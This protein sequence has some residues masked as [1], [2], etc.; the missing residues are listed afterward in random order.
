MNQLREL[1]PDQDYGFRMTMWKGAPIDFFQSA[2]TTG[3]ILAER[4][5]CLKQ[6]A[7]VY[8]SLTPEGMSLLAEANEM[9]Q[10]WGLPNVTDVVELAGSWEPDILFLSQDFEGRFRLRGGSLCFPT[11]WALEEKLGLTLESIHGIVPG[12]NPAIGRA[13]D[14]FLAGLKSG[15]A[16]RRDNWGIAAT[17]ELNLHPNRRIAPPG[18]PVHLD[19]MWLRVE[20]QALVSLPKNNGVMFAIRIALHRLDDLRKDDIVA[21]GLIRAL[22]T[23]P[24]EVAAYKGLSRVR[25]G[26]ITL[27]DIGG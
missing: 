23:M 26:L 13:I 18:L 10:T 22:R 27:L 16:F 20:H 17:D 11:G 9:G 21:Q 1:F 3:G 14:Q 25:D 7:G 5:R 6:D 24:R 2:D 15:L 12:L 8:A 19:R 4:V